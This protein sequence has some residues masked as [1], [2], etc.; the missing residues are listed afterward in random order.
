[1]A[2][3]ILV[4]VATRDEVAHGIAAS[5]DE[6]A[7]LKNRSGRHVREHLEIPILIAVAVDR[8]AEAASA[9]IFC[10]IVEIVGAQPSRKRI[11]VNERPEQ[12]P[13]VRSVEPVIRRWGIA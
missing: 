12:T 2:S 4:Q 9:E 13:V 6:A 3:D 10:V 1:M 5:R 11:R 8:A 7:R